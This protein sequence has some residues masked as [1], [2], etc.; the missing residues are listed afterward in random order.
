MIEAGAICVS[1]RVPRPTIARGLRPDTASTASG[2]ASI[3]ARECLEDV[4]QR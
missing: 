3:V 4:G 1:D 2:S